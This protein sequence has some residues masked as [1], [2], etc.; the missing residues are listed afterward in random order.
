MPTAYLIPLYM[1]STCTYC[2][3][4]TTV[5]CVSALMSGDKESVLFPSMEGVTI[6]CCCMQCIVHASHLALPVSWHYC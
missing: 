5:L 2:N 3:K 4:M 6:V 1:P